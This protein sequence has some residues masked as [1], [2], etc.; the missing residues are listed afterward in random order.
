MKWYQEHVRDR[1]QKHLGDDGTKNMWEIGARNNMGDD[2]TKSMWE[3]GARNIWE[4]R[5]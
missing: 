1:S 3:I 5:W 2:G 4:M